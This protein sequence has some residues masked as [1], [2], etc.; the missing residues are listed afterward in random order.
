MFVL[1]YCHKRGREVRLDREKSATENPIDGSD[2]VEELPDDPLLP[3]PETPSAI[4]RRPVGASSSRAPVS[5]MSGDLSPLPVGDYA[6]STSSR[7]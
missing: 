6:Y 5:P 7:R 2:R 3:A 4:H 1:W